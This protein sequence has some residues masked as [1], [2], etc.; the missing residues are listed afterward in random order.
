MLLILL[1]C[2]LYFFRARTAIVSDEK[3]MGTVKEE[4]C[5]GRSSGS[6]VDWLHAFG[7]CGVRLSEV[8]V[9]DILQSAIS[10]RE[11]VRC[12]RPWDDG[13]GTDHQGTKE[14][15]DEGHSTNWK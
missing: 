3:D 10:H 6:N 2:G 13:I 7:V 11:I 1:G 14:E 9:H 5:I 8:R 4:S 15:G 12:K